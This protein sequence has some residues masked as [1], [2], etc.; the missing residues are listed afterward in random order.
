MGSGALEA[1]VGAA[2]SRD[3]Q[4]T[5]H[6]SRIGG[7]FEHLL[8]GSVG[9]DRGDLGQYQGRRGIGWVE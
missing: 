4:E 2:L 9:L 1:L 6:P 5:V 7:L 3:T 8:M